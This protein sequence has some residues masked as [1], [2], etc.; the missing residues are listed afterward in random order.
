[1]PKYYDEKGPPSSRRFPSL[2]EP[3]KF[4]GYREHQKEVERPLPQ[5]L[6]VP[7]HFLDGFRNARADRKS[8]NSRELRRAWIDAHA[9]LYAKNTLGIAKPNQ[10]DLRSIKRSEGFKNAVANMFSSYD[11]DEELAGEAFYGDDDYELYQ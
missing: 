10:K 1:M 9:T 3:G 5:P 4:V 7:R 11:N 8:Y 6:Q 2:K